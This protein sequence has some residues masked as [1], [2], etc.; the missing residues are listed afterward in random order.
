MQ[1]SKIAI[2]NGGT[3]KY[4]LLK[5]GTF[6]MTVTNNKIQ[7]NYNRELAKFNLGFNFGIINKLKK[8]FFV[9]KIKYYLNNNELVEKKSIKAFNFI[10]N[11]SKENVLKIIKSI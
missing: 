11:N 2:I 6:I 3:T 4:E 5:C 10:D 7:N 1:K 8:E 9:S